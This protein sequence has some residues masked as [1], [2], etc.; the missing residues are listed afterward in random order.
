MDTRDALIWLLQEE[1]R[2]LSEELTGV[3]RTRISTHHD[4]G[5]QYLRFQNHLH[6]ILVDMSDVHHVKIDKLK[7]TQC[8][9]SFYD[10]TNPMHPRRSWY[11]WRHT[12]NLFWECELPVYDGFMTIRLHDED[13]REFVKIL[14]ELAEHNR[15]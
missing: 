3:Y 8:L 7:D 10:E 12:G 9:Y 13:F 14:R 6:D 15:P 4:D 2:A 5:R 11:C 1:V